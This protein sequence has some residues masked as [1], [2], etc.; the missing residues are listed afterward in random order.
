V[1]SD[2]VENPSP[3]PPYVAR[4]PATVDIKPEAYNMQRQA[5]QVT[6]FIELPE[7]YD[8]RDIN[9]STLLLDGIF[10]ARPKPTEVGDYDHDGVPDLMVKFDVS[11][12]HSETNI[13]GLASERFMSVTVAVTG[14]LHDGTLFQGTDTIKIILPN[15]K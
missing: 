10:S 15:P 6:A 12:L 1:V 2:I 14:R 9:V 3:P 4:I 8:V 13:A 11:A 5:N 7:G